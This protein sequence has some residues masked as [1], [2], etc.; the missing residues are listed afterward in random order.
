MTF[1]DFLCSLAERET[2]VARGS[3]H[4]IFLVPPGAGAASP[5]PPRPAGGGAL[6]PPRHPQPLLTRVVCSGC[7]T[8]LL[9]T[10]MDRSELEAAHVCD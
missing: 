2:V 10:W 8:E 7:D 4:L 6:P 1:T 3:S 9:S 5:R